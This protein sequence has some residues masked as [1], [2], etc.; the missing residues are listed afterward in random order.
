MPA[1]MCSLLHV[2]SHL[3][4]TPTRNR[5]LFLITK[6][7]VLSELITVTNS[8]IWSALFPGSWPPS[9]SAACPLPALCSWW[10][11]TVETT[12]PFTV[13]A[14]KSWRPPPPRL[15]V[16][17]L[18]AWIG[19][20]FRQTSGSCLYLFVPQL[21]SWKKKKGR[22]N[23]RDCMTGLTGG[24]NIHIPLCS[25]LYIACHIHAP[26][27]RA[28]YLWLGFFRCLP[29]NTLPS[30]TTVPGSMVAITSCLRIP[31]QLWHP[32]MPR[33]FLILFLIQQRCL[34][35]TLMWHSKNRL[36]I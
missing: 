6:L 2:L 9:D 30:A 34:Q 15:Q 13:L 23:N 12:P 18:T 27:P 14:A 22:V 24:F 11:P 8:C 28:S 1:A 10:V 3:I 19:V 20:L 29:R 31:T 21:L 17:A 32:Q 7:I 35:C 33:G 25:V 16:R 36:I 4:F 26:C 5:S